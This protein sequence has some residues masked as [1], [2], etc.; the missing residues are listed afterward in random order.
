MVLNGLSVGILALIS[1]QQQ[2]NLKP[3][4]RYIGMTQNI[5]K[6]NQIVNRKNLIYLK[7]SA[8]S[9][10]GESVTLYT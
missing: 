5:A 6:P 1:V 3:N 10:I 9:F 2:Y 7:L 4:I 8:I